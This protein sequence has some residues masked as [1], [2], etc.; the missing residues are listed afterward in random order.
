MTLSSTLAHGLRPDPEGQIVSHQAEIIIIQAALDQHFTVRWCI[1]SGI[2]NNGGRNLIQ[3]ALL[4]GVRP[5]GGSVS[6]AVQ[7]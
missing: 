6:S 7:G 1:F 5:F 2:S 3:L 4:S